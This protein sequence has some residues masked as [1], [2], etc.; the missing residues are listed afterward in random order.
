MTS[1]LKEQPS[2]KRNLKLFCADFSLFLNNIL[3]NYFGV[4]R[5][6][7]WFS[8]CWR[9]K[10]IASSKFKGWGW[11]KKL[12]VVFTAVEINKLSKITFN[13]I[14]LMQICSLIDNGMN[15]QCITLNN[16]IMNFHI[17]ALRVITVVCFK[18]STFETNNEK[19]F[20]K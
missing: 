4:N 1:N 16:L 11:G 6:I 20:N 3:L 12:Q 2:E 13:I 10:I 19:Y 18:F 14:I 17:F 15:F 8:I 5:V 7:I 9:W